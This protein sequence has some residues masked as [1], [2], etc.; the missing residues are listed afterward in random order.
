MITENTESTEIPAAEEAGFRKEPL[1][2][3]ATLTMRPGE[4]ILSIGVV[5][6]YGGGMALAR[7]VIIGR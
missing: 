5:D 1:T 7:A 3:G 6:H 2:F 4:N